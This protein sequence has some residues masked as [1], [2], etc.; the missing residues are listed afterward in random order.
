MRE[1]AKI[2]EDSDVRG[3]WRAR[4]QT[5][6]WPRHPRNHLKRSQFSK[7]GDVPVSKLNHV[8]LG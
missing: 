3:C 7:L 5:W 4:A 1:V 2:R 8:D 6:G